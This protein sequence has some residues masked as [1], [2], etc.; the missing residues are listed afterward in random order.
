MYATHVYDKPVRVTSV[1]N[2]SRCEELTPLSA[3]AYANSPRGVF[4]PAAV[5]VTSVGDQ[6]VDKST[7]LRARF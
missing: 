3:I 4:S 6:I 7:L 2:A 5:T 1:D